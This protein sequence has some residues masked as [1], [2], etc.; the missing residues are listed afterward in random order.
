MKLSASGWT[1]KGRTAR[2]DLELGDIAARKVEKITGWGAGLGQG[3]LG[4]EVDTLPDIASDIEAEQY[5]GKCILALAGGRGW[6]ASQ[7]VGL[8]SSGAAARAARYLL[9]KRGIRPSSS[10]LE[11]AASA[12]S[13]T[14][15]IAVRRWDKVKREHWS[16]GRLARYLFRV[17]WRAAFRAIVANEFTGDRASEV[18]E[19]VPLAS[20][21][22]EVEQASLDAW[23]NQSGVMPD[24]AQEEARRAVASFIWRTLVYSCRGRGKQSVRAARQRARVLI[25]LLH[26]QS[27]A[28]AARLAGYGAGCR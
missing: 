27:F 28:D 1:E 19:N 20:G 25:R 5:N 26:G 12:A 3:R 9:S 6:F 7:P 13:A 14:M 23:A 24:S 15:A 22:L 2:F 4:E 11:E 16:N 17:G 18:A 21:T 10:S 8:N